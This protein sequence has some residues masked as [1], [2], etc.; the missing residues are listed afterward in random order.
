MSR[1]NLPLATVVAALALAAIVGGCTVP[2]ETHK[3]T[4]RDLDEARAELGR[5]KEDKRRLESSLV[6][7]DKQIASLQALGEKR[8]AKMFHVR[9][10]KLGRYTGGVDLDDKRGHDGVRVYV[11][12]VDQHGTTIKA[13]GSV[14]IELYDLA[15]KGDAKL[16]GAYRWSADEAAKAWASFVV[17][18][19]RFDC[20][21][22]GAPPKHADITV[23]VEF[24]DYL[25]GKRFTTQRACKVE[26]PRDASPATKPVK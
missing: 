5:L 14:A 23:R 18:H 8:L 24:V 15:A 2:V 25:T 17:Y 26:L 22:K 11:E 3:K 13:A 4:L 10:I 12:P 21:W 7:K 19:Y 6:E 20:R 9:R 16:L 1:G